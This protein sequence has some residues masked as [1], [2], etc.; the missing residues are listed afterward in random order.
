M[1]DGVRRTW[2]KEQ[3]LVR[4]L[5]TMMVPNKVPLLKVIARVLPA[6][7]AA[8]ASKYDMLHCTLYRSIHRTE[9]LSIMSTCPLTNMSE[10]SDER[11]SPIPIYT[12]IVIITTT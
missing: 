3:S 9:S 10:G 1:L 5:G 11:R 7:T 4:F 12:M 8:D 6:F 2:Q